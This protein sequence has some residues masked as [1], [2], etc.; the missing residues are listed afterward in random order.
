MALGR[1]ARERENERPGVRDKG[2]KKESGVVH[3]AGLMA[4]FKKLFK[5]IKL[6]QSF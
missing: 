4:T 2:R 5:I 1:A 3:L 6:P